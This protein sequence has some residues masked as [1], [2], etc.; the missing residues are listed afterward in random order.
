MCCLNQCKAEDT[1]FSGAPVEAGFP[2]RFCSLNGSC[3]KLPKQVWTL[4][5]IKRVLVCRGLSRGWKGDNKSALR[6]TVFAHG[7]LWGYR[8]CACN[9]GWHAETEHVET[10]WTRVTFTSNTTG[11][12]ECCNPLFWP[13][14]CLSSAKSS[15]PEEC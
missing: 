14:L 11:P 15:L 5:P 12:R 8:C 2:G 13:I 3:W 4:V 1:F 9:A 10:G 7:G 6:M